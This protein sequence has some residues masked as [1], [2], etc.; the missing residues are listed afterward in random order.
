MVK[1][2]WKLRAAILSALVLSVTG[3]AQTS[4]VTAP[5]PE[6]PRI[7]ALPLQARQ[8]AM[9]SICSPTCSAGLTTQRESW[10][11]SLT[12]P[13]PPAAPASAPTMPRAP[14]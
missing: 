1:N 3:C 10:R 5:P 12:W 2:V 11:A 7:P 4:T 6:P 8:P 14:N 13:T 9:P